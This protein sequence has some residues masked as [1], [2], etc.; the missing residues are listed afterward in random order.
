MSKAVDNLPPTARGIALLLSSTPLVQD[1]QPGVLHQLLEFAHRYTLQVLTDAK[2]Y[3]EHAGRSENRVDMSD[4]VLAVQSRV[5]WEYG[6][7]VPQE[8]CRT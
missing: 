8:V 7:R 5:G 3:A 4:V 2:V 1:S 6:G